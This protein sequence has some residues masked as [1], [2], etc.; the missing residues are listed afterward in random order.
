MVHS[1]ND[2]RGTRRHSIRVAS[3]SSCVLLAL[4]GCT[5]VGP[6][7][8]VAAAIDIPASW[9]LSAGTDS[10]S[11]SS[12]A[13]W[14]SRFDDSL[15]TGLVTDALQAN[16]SVKSAKAALREARAL[17]DVAAAALLPAINASTSAQRSRHD[18]VTD[19]NYQAGLD[20]SWELDF[21]GANRSALKASDATAW[22]AAAT[23]GDVQVSIAAEVAL[24][25]ISLRGYQ[26]RF[27][28]ATANLE[29]QQ[30]TL[31]I[32]KWRRQAGLVTSLD[33]EQARTVVEQTRAQL[34]ALQTSIEQS[35]HALAVLTGRPPAAL[36]SVLAAAG[37]VPQASGEI[38]LNI[39]AEML[40]QRPDVR[41]AEHQV[42][43]ASA[44]LAQ[45]NA[46]RAPN[47]TLGG[48]LGLSALTLGTLTNGASVVS[49]ML[50]GA[51]LPVFHG[52]ALSAQVRAQRAALDQAQLAYQT[53]VLTALAEVEDSLIA[54]ADDRERLRSLE[55]AAEAAAHAALLAQQ[56]YNSGLVDFQVVLETQR[57]L[58]STQE[59]VAL[60]RADL[61]ADH[62]FL[63]KALGG[64]WEGEDSDATRK[65]IIATPQ[66]GAS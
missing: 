3:T 59:G 46:L 28:I 42:T 24:S 15:L 55:E 47:F 21:F 66:P 16:P 37:T 10:T 32:T 43:V 61:S 7:R 27:A 29:S 51:S 14:W 48:S 11:P 41:A 36:S 62:V 56:Q 58:L 38:T 18:S 40:R 45:A 12:L 52:G 57:A 60:A 63:Y 17:R 44:R 65:A 50:A 1:P 9:S 20:A 25:Y 22:A 30:E 53:T 6:E 26:E 23:L 2:H 39:P 34:P 8:T 33:S 64:G 19:N 13:Q 5:S 35:R 49:S 4:C 31:Q 54:L